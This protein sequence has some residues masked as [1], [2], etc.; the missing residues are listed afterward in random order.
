MSR[1]SHFGAGGRYL[2][3]D[4]SNYYANN[5][6]HGIDV[7]IAHAAVAVL[8]NKLRARGMP[9]GGSS[10]RYGSLGALFRGFRSAQKD[11]AGHPMR[12]LTPHQRQRMC[13]LIPPEELESIYR[14]F[15]WD[16]DKPEVLKNLPLKPPRK[17]NDNG[18][19]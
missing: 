15:S 1:N 18:D 2:V 5:P 7:A 8:L 13:A 6:Q 4:A 10:H 9:L 14:R 11:L 16:A 12:T 3:S 17:A 19:E